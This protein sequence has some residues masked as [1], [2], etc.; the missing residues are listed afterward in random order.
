[1]SYLAL[2]QLSFGCGTISN[3]PSCVKY[4]KKVEFEMDRQAS[5]T[6][7]AGLLILVRHLARQ[8]VSPPCY[9]IFHIA[10]PTDIH[11]HRLLA[12]ACVSL[13]HFGFSRSDRWFAILFC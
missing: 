5:P 10:E 4:L 9:K 1:M 11:Q 7:L 8:L 13:Q 6:L 12:V 2:T 3:F